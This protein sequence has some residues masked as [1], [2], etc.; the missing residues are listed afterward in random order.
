MRTVR[1]VLVLVTCVLAVPAAASGPIAWVGSGLRA[2]PWTRTAPVDRVR[3]GV[4][5]EGVYGVSAE[6]IASALGVSAVE[7]ATA[8]AATNLALSCQGNTVA[9]TSDGSNLL[10]YGVAAPSRLAPE[11]VYWLQKGAG[12]AMT[13]AGEVPPGSSGTNRWFFDTVTLQGTNEAGYLALGALTNVPSYLA[14]SLVGAKK[15]SKVTVSLPDVAGGA[16]S[17][18]ATVVLLSA[19]NYESDTDSH[20]AQVF[21]SGSLLGSPGW[22]GE[23]CLTFSY[24]FSG[25]SPLTET[26]SVTVTN[27]GTG[28]NARFW[29]SRVAVT[30]PRLYRA[31][32]DTL[33]CTGG[34]AGWV[35][36]QG[37]S[38]S[39]LAVW[40]VTCPEQ[41]EI[42][43]PSEI[44]YD[45]DTAAWRVA[46]PSGGSDQS[47]AAFAAEGGVLRPSVRGVCDADGY[48]ADNQADYVVLIPPEGWVGGF[49]ETVQPL[50]D[51]RSKQGLRTAIVDVEALYN[52]FS[53]GLADPQAIH[54]FCVAGQ[55]GPD[56]RLRYLLLAGSGSLDFKQERASVTDY[57]ACLIPT[58]IAGQ[59]I[60]AT[61]TY[62]VVVT[63]E[64][65]IVAV[66]QAFGDV[67]GDAA[68]EVAVGR[69]PTARTQELAVAVSKTLA[70]E[71]VAAW[72]QKAAVAANWNFV[73]GANRVSAA[74]SAAGRSVTNFYP[75]SSLDNLQPVWAN[76]LQPALQK[77]AGL[78]FFIGDSSPTFLGKS[79]TYQLMDTNSLKSVTWTNIPIAV[80]MSCRVNFWQSLEAASSSPGCLA[81]YGVFL[82]GSGFSAALASTGYVTPAEGEQFALFLGETA[83]SNGVTR[84][85]DAVCA[86]LQRLAPLAPPE[87]LQSFS[88]VGDPALS[89]RY[90]L[91]G[92]GT[93]AGWLQQYGLTNWNGDV[94]DA[95]QDGWPAWQEYRQGTRPDTNS[96]VIAAQRA[97]ADEAWRMITFEAV[98]NGR[99]EVQWKPSLTGPDD[100]QAVVWAWPGHTDQPQT[101]VEIVPDAPLT[102]ICVT[103]PTGEPQG[104]YRIRRL[105]D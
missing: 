37:F 87:R 6:E 35:D 70:Y 63:N 8:M 42:V 29:W 10:F 99:Y 81:P 2:R 9:W 49:R 38:S 80:L 36:V 67:A 60:V 22:S 51:F 50:V 34:A 75:A 65:M 93:P 27:T 97:E 83:A 3:L 96:L 98:A 79:T 13:A 28:A 57:N 47:Y 86:A 105:P 48:A 46:F 90:D 101:G 55:V 12:T 69:L 33:R 21:V 24:P 77:G 26:V 58:L 31:R 61:N 94:S 89:W 103:Q 23:Q 59:R 73:A 15:D 56:V 25:V 7:I 102:A 20:A 16:V 17:G 40:D 43:A 32:N 66:D 71:A 39:A 104:F 11:N 54:D 72:K 44:L 1:L 91:T 88:L 84:L 52:R 19:C 76:A 64:A 53:E 62:N 68:P 92:T 78:F 18:Q 74:L 41:P 85:G 30:Y 14:F 45:T 4:R 82:S 95:D 5:S 100:W